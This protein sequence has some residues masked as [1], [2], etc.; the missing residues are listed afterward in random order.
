M[1]ISTF[2][3]LPWCISA[4][5]SPPQFSHCHEAATTES[6]LLRTHTLGLIGLGNIGRQLARRCHHGF[7]M[8]IHYFDVEQIPAD[9][10][11]EIKAT[12]HD[13][14][15]SLL[16]AVDCI[17]LC[18]P[19]SKGTIVNASTLRHFRAGARFVNVARGSLVDE[20]A[21]CQALQEGHISAAALDVHASE[22]NVHLGLA[23][24]AREEGRVMLTCHNAG[25]TL[26]THQGFEELSMRNVM[27]VL[28]GEQPIT[29]VNLRYLA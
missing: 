18:T 19:A 7:G 14:L 11:A 1:I 22:P 17:V 4:A 26:E 21:L 5:T 2:R 25:G 28:G 29:P 23:K 16:G 3:H 20:D 8:R 15:E 12:A 9:I 27:A 24:I 13:S 10:A 6:R